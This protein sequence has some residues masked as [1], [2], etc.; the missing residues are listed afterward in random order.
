MRIWRYRHRPVVVG[1][2]I[3]VVND[4]LIDGTESRLLVDGEERD[5]VLVT[6]S[7]PNPMAVQ[8]LAATLPDGRRL[9]VDT[10]YNSWWATGANAFVDDALIWESHPGRPVA[11]PAAVTALFAGKRGPTHQADVAQMKRNWPVM[12]CDMA[13]AL[14][15]YVVAK[16]T[17]LPTAAITSAVAGLALAVVQRFVKVDLLGGLASFGIVMSLLSAGLAIAMRDDR[18]VMMRST[19]LGTISALAF[20]TDGALGGRW[21][22]KGIARYLPGISDPRRMALGMG[23]LGLVLAGLEQA[24]IVLGGKDPWLTYTTFVEMPVGVALVF[25][26]MRWA[27]G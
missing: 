14:L 8:S 7:S 26:V 27:R 21:L 1:H 13:L 15:F 3:L 4:A 22:G 11:P 24:V 18:A 5:R 17:D 19:I 2:D 6:M 16:M 25:F 23:L 10:G 9:R 12:A 20:L